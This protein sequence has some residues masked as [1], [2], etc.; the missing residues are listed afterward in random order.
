MYELINVTQQLLS[1][2][3]PTVYIS[4]AIDSKSWRLEKT[5]QT[6][7]LFQLLNLICKYCYIFKVNL[8]ANE[9]KCKQWCQQEFPYNVICQARTTTNVYQA[10]NLRKG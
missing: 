6:N 9:Q 5:A 10:A 4:F 2:W 7:Q 1:F 3:L 8:F